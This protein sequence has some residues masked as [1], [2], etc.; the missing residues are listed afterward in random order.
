MQSKQL[1]YFILVRFEKINKR[2][3]LKT[4]VWGKEKSHSLLLGLETIAV[5]MEINV[6]NYYKTKNK[7]TI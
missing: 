7:S 5:S 4:N 2:K 6:K 1:G 3:R